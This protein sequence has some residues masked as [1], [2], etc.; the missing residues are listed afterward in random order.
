[1][2]ATQT[3]LLLSLL[4]LLLFPIHTFAQA[5]MPP[6][7]HRMD[8]PA[9]PE[10]E[11]QERI[12]HD[13]AK[14]ANQARQAALKSDTEKLV[15]LT[16]ELKEYVDKSNENMLSLDVIKKAEEIEKLAKSVKEKMK[17]QN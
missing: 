7:V 11:T 14:K 13:L 6:V 4:L 12:A 1:M 8:N 5:G 2:R 15:R 17:G 9:S 16:G 10:D 3:I